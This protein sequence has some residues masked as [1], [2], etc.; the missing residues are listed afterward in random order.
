MV[1]GNDSFRALPINSQFRLENSPQGNNQRFLRFPLNGKVNGLL[2]LAD[3]RGVIQ[4]A[5]TEILPVPQ[6]AE[7]LLGIMNWRGEAIWILDLASL[8]GATHWC[9]RESVRSSGMAMLVQVQNQTVGLLVEQVNSIEVYDPQERLAVSASMLPARLGSFLQGYFVDSQGSP[10]ML[11][12][13][14]VVIQALQSL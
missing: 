13:T 8:L 2:P 1:Q 10:L 7:F 12:D 9:R 3:L 4:V 14:H 6:V 5:L 11:I